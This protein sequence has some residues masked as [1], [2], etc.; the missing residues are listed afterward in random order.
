[1]SEEN[2]FYYMSAVHLFNTIKKKL[3]EENIESDL[4][5][6]REFCIKIYNLADKYYD[7]E[8]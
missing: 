1:M 3:R 8:N 5:E 2:R 6:L 4:Y 7:F